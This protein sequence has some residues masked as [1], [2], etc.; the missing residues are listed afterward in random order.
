[1]QVSQE[2]DR[3]PETVW[4]SLLCLL[5]TACCA[6]SLAAELQGQV[7]RVSDG[8]TLI[9]LDAQRQQ[10]TIRLTGID[11]PEKSQAFGPESRDHLAQAVLNQAVTVAYDKHDKYGRIVGKVLAQGV[12]ANLAQLQAGWAWHYRQYQREQSAEDRS[13]YSE[14]ESLA[15]EAQKGLWQG[16]TPP[17]PP[18]D[19]RARI[20]AERDRPKP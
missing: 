18:W 3:S 6:V 15:R 8:D 11:A 19:Y 12:D 1:M 17:E 9:V 16:H 4:R 2:P 5:L 10:H 7:I 14:T 13:L 20:K